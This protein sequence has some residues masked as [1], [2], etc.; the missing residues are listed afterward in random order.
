MALVAVVLALTV[1]VAVC[2]RVVPE[3]RRLA[4]FRLGRFRGAAGPGLVFVLPVID[5]A[6]PIDLD[7]VVPEWRALGNHEIAARVRLTTTAP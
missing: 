6:S 5:H 1:G 7:E 2:V 3:N 4:V